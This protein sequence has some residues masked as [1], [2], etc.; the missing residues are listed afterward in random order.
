MDTMSVRSQ[1]NFSVCLYRVFA[2]CGVHLGGCIVGDGIIWKSAV[3][4]HDVYAVPL[5]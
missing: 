5:T 2:Y 1:N 3:Q 4:V